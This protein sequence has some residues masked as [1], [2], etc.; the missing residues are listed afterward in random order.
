MSERTVSN[1]FSRDV[2]ELLTSRGMNLTEIA[3]LL[4]VTKSYVSRVKAGKRSFT[5]DHLAV[6]EK[7]LGRPAPLL[8]MEAIPRETVAPKARPLYD[9]T[10]KLLRRMAEPGPWEK[11]KATPAAGRKGK[12]IKAA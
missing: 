12:R 1:R 4:G 9:A 3:K 10:I 8:L 6:L 7:E 5:L 2:V 11:R